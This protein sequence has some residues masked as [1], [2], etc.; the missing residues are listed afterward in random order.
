MKIVSIVGARPQFIK[1]A[2]VSRV[3]RKSHSE[4]LVHAGQ[5][6]DKGLSAV[7]FNELDIPKS[8]YNLGVGSGPHGWQTGQMLA[9]VEDVLLTERPDWVLVYGDTNS[10]LAGAFSAQMFDGLIR[11][12]LWICSCWSNMLR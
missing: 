10:T 7:F 5:H 6:Y 2:P 9:R 11:L 12:V 3:L 8:D 1:A 4:I